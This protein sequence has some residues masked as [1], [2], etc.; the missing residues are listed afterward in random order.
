MPK[1]YV[2]LISTL[3]LLTAPAA[4][5]QSTIYKYDNHGR[6]I[7]VEDS[8]IGV[9]SYEYDDAG[10][11]VDRTVTPG[12]TEAPPT[13]G[14]VFEGTNSSSLQIYP[15]SSC[16]DPNGDSLTITSATLLSNNGTNL[17]Y[18]STQLTFTN[19]PCDQ[20]FAEFSVSD[21]N[22]GSTTGDVEIVRLGN[23]CDL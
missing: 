9:I 23:G 3:F 16:S 1:K 7:S 18:T 4:Y 17:S 22:G 21:G 10:N 20:T 15:L 2:A 13:C 19:L 8:V 12:G 5:A 6:V 11:L 14:L